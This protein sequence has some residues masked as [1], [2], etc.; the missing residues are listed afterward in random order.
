MLRW[1]LLH[2][3]DVDSLISLS[4]GPKPGKKSE[5][6]L[7][8]KI[9]KRLEIIPPKQEQVS[10]CTALDR[11]KITDGSCG[12]EFVLGFLRMAPSSPHRLEG[13]SDHLVLVTFHVPK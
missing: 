1:D 7:R 3:A 11:D 13:E 8:P 2:W 5:V 9:P 6:I 10:V 4:Q 12:G